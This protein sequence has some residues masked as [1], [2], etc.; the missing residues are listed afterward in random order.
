MTKLMTPEFSRP[1]ACDGLKEGPNS[2][3]IEAAP[4]E[5]TALAERFSLI[6]IDSLSA[7]VTLTPRQDSLVL[8]AGK[9]RADVTQTCVITL[10]PVKSLIEASFEQLYSGEAD[11]GEDEDVI[12]LLDGANDHEPVIDGVID[13]GEAVAEQMAVELPL[14]PRKPGVK[15]EDF[16]TDRDACPGAETQSGPFAE[17]GKL[18]K[19]EK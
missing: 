8:M 9:L 13:L 6:S 17:L 1:V 11:S 12:I 15:F 3:D 10:E 19:E 4:R 7:T 16:T 18:L 14:F 2:F 5:R